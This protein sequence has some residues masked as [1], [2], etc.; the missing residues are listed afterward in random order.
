MVL[1][2]KL[3]EHLWDYN[4]LFLFNTVSQKPSPA[5]SSLAWSRVSSPSNYEHL[6]LCGI[7]VRVKLLRVSDSLAVKTF[8]LSFQS[9]FLVCWFMVIQA[10]TAESICHRKLLVVRV[11]DT[12]VL[13]N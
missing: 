7:R 11:R 3:R 6:Q 8:R 9:S 12:A 2:R 1:S 13:K 10:H 5:L 4:D